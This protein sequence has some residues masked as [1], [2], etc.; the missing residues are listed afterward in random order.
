M[1]R[2]KQIIPFALKLEQPF[3]STLKQAVDLDE[4]QFHSNLHTQKSRHKERN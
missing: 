4:F 3:A 1:R 2:A